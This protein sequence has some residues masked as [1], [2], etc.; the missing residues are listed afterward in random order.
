MGGE[1]FPIPRNG[2]AINP[3][4]LS[5]PDLSCGH[6]K[7]T[8]EKALQ[9]LPIQALKVDLARKEVSFDAEATLLP[10]VLRRLDAEGYPAEPLQGA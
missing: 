1:P 10:E 6:C 2:V 9:G 3:T 4:T 7:A 8:V 5:V